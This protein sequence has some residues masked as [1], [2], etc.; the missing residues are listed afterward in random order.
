MKVLAARSTASNRT[1]VSVP[2]GRVNTTRP[3]L[4]RPSAFDRLEDAVDVHQPL[5]GGSTARRERR[6]DCGDQC[7]LAEDAPVEAHAQLSPVEKW[8]ALK[9]TAPAIE[10]GYSVSFIRY[11]TIAAGRRRGRCR[12][13]P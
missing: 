12:V 2:P 8:C 11:G 13:T 4:L 10:P 6:D 5:V 1:E 9:N 7:R 3:S